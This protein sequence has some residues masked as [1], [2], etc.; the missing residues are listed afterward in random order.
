MRICAYQEGGLGVFFAHMIR[1]HWV[2][3][4]AVLAAMLLFALPALA[5]DTIGITL[6]VEPAELT[7]PGPVTVSIRV[8]NN[9]PDMSEPVLLYDPDGQIVTAFGDGGQALLRQGEFVTA[10][11]TYNVTQAQL[12][13]GKLTY[14]LSYNSVDESGNVTV[15][16]LAQ[17]ADIV[18][19]GTNVDL[20]VNRTIDPEVVRSGKTVTVQYELYNAGNVEIK[21][22][23]IRENSSISGTAQSVASLQPGER[24]SIVFTASMGNNNVTSEGK[25]TYKAGEESYS[26]DLAAV[27]IPKASPNLI[28]ND[29]LKADKTAITTGETVTLTL[30]IENKGNITYSNVSVTD[31]SFGEIFTNL[32]IGPG[33]TLVREKQFTLTETKTF[34]YTVTL[35]D[36]TG[37]TN[38]VTSNEIKVS[39]YDPTQV[40][41]LSVT[42]ET[43][44]TVVS[45]I[46]ADVRFSVTVTNNAAKEAKNI[47][48]LHGN[49]QIYTIS[50]LAPGESYTV[51]RDYSLSQAGKYRFTASVRD[52]LDNTV[53]F[54]SNEIMITYT[55]PTAT[56]TMA[57][58]VTIAPVVTLTAAP[59]EVLE[60]VTLQTNTILR[61]AAMV[62]AGLFGICFILFIISSIARGKNRSERKNALYEMDVQSKR[63]Y[64]KPAAYP[65]S[66]EEEAVPESE[67]KPE[68][69]KPSDEI[70]K[71]AAAPVEVPVED[72]GAYHLTRD[73]SQP[74]AEEP[75]P[76]PAAA[77]KRHRRS[78][79]NVEAPSE[80][81]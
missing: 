40:M 16:Q 14:I 76:Q 60:P 73:D 34:K 39:V 56:P 25:I 61:Y 17:T 49:V 11:H 72:N 20:T 33:E 70:L 64:T 4:L 74:A 75:G 21:N 77:P 51:T 38:T 81:E 6:S 44:T 65:A 30:T 46:P 53:T 45:S 7:A 31:A 24:T 27:T 42:A 50:S 69:T 35:P 57:P 5:D 52:E 3:V 29:I 19:A 37:T 13:A 67:N 23:R 43:P 80:D 58:V 9:G 32:T 47:R 28:L 66:F 22:I 68:T 55:R 48:L 15:R 26:Q 36:N 1:K 54:D 79:R 10:Q 18:F 62:L 63:D 12:N 78:D 8:V 41:M 71:E 59:I 2:L